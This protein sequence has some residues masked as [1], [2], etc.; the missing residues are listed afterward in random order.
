[1]AEVVE[2]TTIWVTALQEQ[3]GEMPVGSSILLPA[4]LR[5][6]EALQ[7][8]AITEVLRAPMVE[9]VEEVLGVLS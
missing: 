3:L 9:A 8:M 4:R 1:M 6:R 2:K 7:A 5:F